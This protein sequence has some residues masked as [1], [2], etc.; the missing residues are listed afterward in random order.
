M[1][2]L[3]DR[4]THLHSEHCDRGQPVRLCDC[5]VARAFRSLERSREAFAYQQLQQ[6]HMTKPPLI[7]GGQGR[8]DEQ[9]HADAVGWGRML[10][11]WFGVLLLCLAGWALVAHLLG[12]L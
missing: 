1:S 10:L 8:T 9:V 12:W 2:D 6:L 5:S 4:Y 11:V 3:L 7:V